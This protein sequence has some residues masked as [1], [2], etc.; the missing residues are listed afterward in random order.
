MT[1]SI[2]VGDTDAR[3]RWTV[4]YIETPIDSFLG[5]LDTPLETREINISDRPMM[6]RTNIRQ[7][8]DPHRTVRSQCHAF[9]KET[10]GR[11]S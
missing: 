1:A 10:S 6:Y 8:P 9:P 5:P 3:S 2:G 11:S 4:E 7:T